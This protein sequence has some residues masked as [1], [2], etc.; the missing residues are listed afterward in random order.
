L[1][2]DELFT[3]LFPFHNLLY[4]YNTL[5]NGKINKV[6]FTFGIY[7]FKNVFMVYI[8]G[9]SR[10]TE[11]GAGMQVL[12]QETDKQGVS[13]ASGLCTIYMNEGVYHLVI[14]RENYI[15]MNLEVIVERGSNTIKA[16]MSPAFNVPAVNKEQVNN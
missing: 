3:F 6:N 1:N 8:N 10:N 12:V 2:A 15:T 5:L 13:N 4:R 7:L 9:I 16:E 11:L 14:S